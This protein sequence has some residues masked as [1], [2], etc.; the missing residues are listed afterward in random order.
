MVGLGLIKMRIPVVD[1]P[2]QGPNILL[3]MIG[4]MCALSSLQIYFRSMEIA[5]YRKK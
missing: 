3:V 5:G 1:I 2:L 4:A